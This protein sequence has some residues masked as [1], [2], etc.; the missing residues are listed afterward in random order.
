MT[1]MAENNIFTWPTAPMPAFGYYTVAS[2]ANPEQYYSIPSPTKEEIQTMMEETL[3]KFFN[4]TDDNKNDKKIPIKFQI[5]IEEDGQNSSNS[6]LFSSV[7]IRIFYE[8][9]NRNGSFIEKT[10]GDAMLKT[11]FNVPIVGEF[12]VEK[13]DFGGLGGKIIISDQGLEFV[14]TSKP[15]GV[16]PSNSSIWWE[17]VTEKDGTVKNYACCNGLLWTGR[18]PEA[19]EVINNSKGQ[20]MELDPNCVT[21]QW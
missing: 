11:I 6:G 18:Y 13:N 2:G 16:I 1:T 4:K 3:N 10:I 7:K 9:E 21:G 5:S 19:L 14:E 20:S 17:Q 15:Y 8:G 12:L